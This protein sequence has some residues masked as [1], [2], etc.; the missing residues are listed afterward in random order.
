M[1]WRYIDEI[2]DAECDICQ[3]CCDP[4]EVVK[5]VKIY[6]MHTCPYCD[7][8]QPQIEGK[9]EQYQYIDIGEHIRNMHEFMDMRDKRPEF[10]H[11]KEI[12]DEACSIE[13]H[14]A[15]KGGC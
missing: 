7:F 11:A 4:K 13:D 12:G 9:E 14:K 2:S 8:L 15:G 5:L 6:G 1:R 3:R 10:D